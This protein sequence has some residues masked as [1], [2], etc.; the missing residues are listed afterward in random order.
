MEEINFDVFGNK[1]YISVNYV[2][3]NEKERYYDEWEKL[4]DRVFDMKHKLTW[5]I[6]DSNISGFSRGLIPKNPPKRV[7]FGRKSYSCKG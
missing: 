1:D 3:K 7:S 2:D 6:I 4:K 5:D